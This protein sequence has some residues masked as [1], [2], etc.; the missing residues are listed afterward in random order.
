MVALVCSCQA[1]SRL[2]TIYPCTLSTEVTAILYQAPTG[3]LKCLW[4]PVKAEH[5]VI[6]IHENACLAVVKQHGLY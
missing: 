4:N 1:F 5:I 2:V 3:K 6:K